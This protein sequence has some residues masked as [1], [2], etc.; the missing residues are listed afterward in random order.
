[1][2]VLRTVGDVRAVLGAETRDSESEMIGAEVG[3]AGD[4]QMAVGY[5]VAEEVLRAISVGNVERKEG[6]R[7][8]GCGK[9][10]RLNDQVRARENA[11]NDKS[12]GLAP[13]PAK[14]TQMNSDKAGVS[15]GE[16]GRRIVID[17]IEYQSTT[18]DSHANFS[19][20]VSS[21]T[22]SNSNVNRNGDQTVWSLNMMSGD[23]VKIDKASLIA[24]SAEFAAKQAEEKFKRIAD[25]NKGEQQTPG[26]PG[27]AGPM[28]QGSEGQSGGGSS[29]SS[30]NAGVLPNTNDNT[31]TTTFGTGVDEVNADDSALPSSTQT[32]TDTS[33]S[34]ERFRSSPFS[35]SPQDDSLMPESAFKSCFGGIG[36]HSLQ[37]GFGGLLGGEGGSDDGD[38]NAGSQHPLDDRDVEMASL[39]NGKST[40]A[41]GSKPDSTNNSKGGERTGKDGD[42][43]DEK[44]SGKKRPYEEDNEST[45]KEERP[46][47]EIKI[48]N[49]DRESDAEVQDMSNTSLADSRLIC[50]QCLRDAALAADEVDPR[51]HGE[52][53]GEGKGAD[54][55]S[56]NG[57]GDNANKTD[58]TSGSVSNQPTEPP[59]NNIPI[60]VGC[61]REA[62]RRALNETALYKRRPIPFTDML[63]IVARNAAANH[64]V[65]DSDQKP[66]EDAAFVEQ[67]DL[68][69]GSLSVAI[70][71]Y[72]YGDVDELLSPFVAIAGELF[73]GE[74]AGGENA[75]VARMLVRFL[76]WPFGNLAFNVDTG[77]WEDPQ[78]VFG[79]WGPHDGELRTLGDFFRKHWQNILSP[80]Q[81]APPFFA[82]A[83]AHDALR[84][85]SKYR[86]FPEDRVIRIIFW[87]G[88]NQRGELEADIAKG[89]G[90]GGILIWAILVEHCRQFEQLQLW[91]SE[92]SLSVI[93]QV[94]VMTSDD[95]WSLPRLKRELTPL[96]RHPGAALGPLVC[97]C[98]RCQTA[99]TIDEFHKAAIEQ[100]S[101]AYVSMFEH[102][103][104]ARERLGE[105]ERRQLWD[106][107]S[108]KPNYAGVLPH[109]NCVSF[110]FYLLRR[111]VDRICAR[112]KFPIPSVSPQ[113]TVGS[114]R[115]AFVPHESRPSDSRELLDAIDIFV[116]SDCEPAVAHAETKIL[117]YLSSLCERVRPRIDAQEQYIHNVLLLS[118]FQARGVLIHNLPQAEAITRTQLVLS[119]VTLWDL[120][121]SKEEKEL[122]LSNSRGVPT[123]TT[124]T[125]TTPSTA[126]GNGND[127]RSSN[128]ANSSDNID[129]RST[130][131]ANGN[132]NDDKNTTSA[133]HNDNGNGNT[134]ATST[135]GADNATEQSITDV[136]GMEVL[137]RWWEEQEHKKWRARMAE[138][139][140]KLSKSDEDAGSKDAAS[141]KAQPAERA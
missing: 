77:R 27:G 79:W 123:A 85:D 118:R 53:N 106:P 48:E 26:S 70:E 105:S 140:E 127:T 22:L 19:T 31:V 44:I 104:F 34:P 115:M 114:P 124:N 87:Q 55:T 65:A 81:A 100:I 110:C 83:L 59:T 126:D 120:S 57:R 41:N 122:I 73:G 38:G 80:P 78:R 95:A 86:A 16:T 112:N 129:N 61:L 94:L 88:L 91:T 68:E 93:L 29:S 54:N 117:E 92:S 9:E 67:S 30:S 1:M 8:S 113:S 138:M 60:S 45:S 89:T 131:A 97:A 125:G 5:R 58:S 40:G 23:P 47:K 107:N 71:H 130:N 18:E 6:M 20:A 109:T 98:P 128:V 25:E 136:H 21:Q 82:Q 39:Q 111:I 35:S 99:V 72:E 141:N 7:C 137:R 52:G 63:L 102:T 12:A 64:N 36:A 33:F 14:D 2:S 133:N 76:G 49:A 116:R 132:E 51:D 74:S 32:R 62:A 13:P 56:T 103:S 3:D 69:E 135:D 28:G 15:K 42:E 108:P 46:C 37:N 84:R 90:F 24:A 17:G 121:L 4:P 139:V 10:V 101:R 119:Q 134:T 75:D 66:L 11:D 96:F 50:L 43:S